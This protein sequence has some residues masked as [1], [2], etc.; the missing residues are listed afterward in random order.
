GQRVG[1]AR[2]RVGRLDLEA[3][4]GPR[5]AAD[6]AHDLRDAQALDV[7]HLARF[8]LA[9]GDDLVADL[10]PPIFRDDAAGHDLLERRYA[11][12]L[13]EQRAD[14]FER[15]A[16]VDVELIDGARGHVAGVRIVAVGERIEVAL[17][18]FFLIDLRHVALQVAVALLDAVAGVVFL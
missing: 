18:E 2:L 14:A 17:D 10:D 11:V 12:V 6:Q 13:A 16:D 3:H 9:D 8:A 7:D 15:R 1:D 5:L 4:L